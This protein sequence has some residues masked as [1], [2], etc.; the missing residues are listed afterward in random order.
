M[1]EKLQKYPIYMDSFEQ[2]VV[3]ALISDQRKKVP[4]VWEQLTVLRRNFM[5]DA[6]VEIT[7]LGDDIIQMKDNI[8]LIIT[9]KKYEWE[10]VSN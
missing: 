6:G 5:E 2:G 7:D 10:K 9:R 4:R 3:M 8:G 1:E